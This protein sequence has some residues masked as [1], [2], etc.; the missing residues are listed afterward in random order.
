MFRVSVG[1]TVP[2]APAKGPVPVFLGAVG[3]AADD[4]VYL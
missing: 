2:W 3:G 4:A 1:F